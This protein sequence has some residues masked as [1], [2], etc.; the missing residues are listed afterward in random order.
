MDRK[1]KK[2]YI[3]KSEKFYDAG[4][5]TTNERNY[6]RELILKSPLADT[7]RVS[8]GLEEIYHESLQ[9]EKITLKLSSKI[10]CITEIAGFNTTTP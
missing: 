9:S 10:C 4:K 8:E 3:K 1:D 5:R 6:L 2:D 7:K